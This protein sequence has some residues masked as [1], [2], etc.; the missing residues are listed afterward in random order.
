MMPLASWLLCP[1]RHPDLSL[2]SYATV[3]RAAQALDQA[4]WDRHGIKLL[5]CDDPWRFRDMS[6][7]ECA[8]APVYFET[9]ERD[10]PQLGTHADATCRAMTS[11]NFFALVGTRSDRP[12]PFLTQNTAALY[13]ME[14]GA[15]LICH[16]FESRRLWSDNPER[17]CAGLEVKTASASPDFFWALPAVHLGT[18]WVTP[19]R[20]KQ[21]I[22]ET[23]S[24]LHRM[25]A[26]L[27]FGEVPQFG[28]I[29]PDRQHD[30][31]FHGRVIGSVIETRD[32]FSKTST[33]LFYPPDAVV[34]DAAGVLSA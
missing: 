26:W 16:L 4:I 2:S 15:N 19:S 13:R 29:V 31:L 18:A 9:D 25:V 6:E 17:D 5:Y 12:L 1:W 11:E 8:R 21:G 24:R 33:V 3:V 27:K 14:G 32:G 20:R 23:V 22:A 30:K 10:P 34:S 28:T 7:K